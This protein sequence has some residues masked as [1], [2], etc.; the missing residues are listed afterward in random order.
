MAQ[1]ENG[2]RRRNEAIEA[3]ASVL[4]EENWEK[5]DE[6]DFK[7]ILPEA[8]MTWNPDCVFKMKD[9][10]EERIAVE[11]EEIVN[12]PSFLMRFKE[13]HAELLKEIEIA[14]LSLEYTPLSYKVAKDGIASG[15]PI[16]AQTNDPSPVIVLDPSYPKDIECLDANSVKELRGR[17]AQN[18]RIPKCLISE[19]EKVKSMTYSGDLRQFAHDYENVDFATPSAEHIFIKDFFEKRFVPRFSSEGLFEGLNI[20]SLLEEVCQTIAG[21]REHFVHSFQTFLLGSVIIDRFYAS[22]NKMYSSCFSCEASLESAWFFTSVFHDV[23]FPFQH[24]RSWS[25]LGDLLQIDPRGISRF[26]PAF[27]NS[28]LER[29]R[30]QKVGRDWNPTMDSSRGLQSAVFPRHRMNHAVTSAIYLFEIG[31]R[32]ESGIKLTGIYPAALAILVHDQTLWMDL[33]RNAIFPMNMSR[34]PL[35]ALLL[36]CDNIQEWAREQFGDTSSLDGITFGTEGVSNRIWLEDVVANLVTR[37][38]HNLIFGKLIDLED[39]VLE[40]DLRKSP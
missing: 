30:T 6:F 2:N 11:V 28:F 18:K 34:F 3:F 29:I 39:F 15:I 4:E 31:N 8:D 24:I 26:V 17:Y 27:L 14:V 13:Q 36:Y 10:G 16:Y 38:R 9:G 33:I 19:L 12:I 21:K 35:V 20:L 23:T 1:A 7:E 37:S 5:D 25:G 22:F 32:L 40:C